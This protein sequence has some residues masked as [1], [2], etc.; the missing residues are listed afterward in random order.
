MRVTRGRDSHVGT[1][2]T[3]QTRLCKRAHSCWRR[4]SAKRATRLALHDGKR[5]LHSPPALSRPCAPC[6]TKTLLG[7]I[8]RHPRA[9]ADQAS[10]ARK[11]VGPHKNFRLPLD[12]ARARAH[13][14]RIKARARKEP[15]QPIEQNSARRVSTPTTTTNCSSRHKDGPKFLLWYQLVRHHARRQELQVQS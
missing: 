9:L 14:T 2:T 1:A 15:R 4:L 11:K 8:S 10:Y 7:H 6:T 5:H 12:A 3:L 13:G